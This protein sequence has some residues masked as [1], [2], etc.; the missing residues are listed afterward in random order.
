MAKFR[1]FTKEDRLIYSY[2]KLGIF[3]GLSW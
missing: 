1:K 3:N 2:F